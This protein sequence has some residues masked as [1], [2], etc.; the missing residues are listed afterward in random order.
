MR[1]YFS[2]VMMFLFLLAVD[3][4]QAQ[5]QAA[6]PVRNQVAETTGTPITTLRHWKI[7]QVVR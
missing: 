2:L 3:T 6:V 7:R 4:V 1:I 5:N